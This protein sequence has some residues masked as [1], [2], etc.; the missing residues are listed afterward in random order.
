MS[1]KLL[2]RLTQL[3]G[4]ASRVAVM[5]CLLLYTGCAGREQLPY[6]RVMAPLMPGPVCRVAVLPFLNDTDFP[7]ADRIVK[8]IFMAEF[9]EAGD[10]QIL[11]EGDILKTYQQLGIWSR[12]APTLEQMQIVANRVDAQLMVTGIIMEMRE[13]PGRNRAINPK[14]IMQLELRDGRTGEVLW[15]IFHSRKG[16]DYTKTMHFGTI[17]SIA[18]LTRQMA[19]EIINLWFEKGLQ[20]CNVLSRP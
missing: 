5:S 2:P 18:G 6:H 17:N 20:Q 12:R 19:E 7:Q 1:F 11:Q 10:Y 14:I 3:V 9:R 4:K 8:K 15:A 13:D 16:S